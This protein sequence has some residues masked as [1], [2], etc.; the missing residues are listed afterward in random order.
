MCCKGCLLS[1]DS[2]A[3]EQATPVYT[4]GLD[5]D[6]CKRFYCSHGAYDVEEF[7][8][9]CGKCRAQH[10][11]GYAKSTDG[12]VTAF[13]MDMTDVLRLNRLTYICVKVVDHSIFG[14]FEAEVAM[15]TA[16]SM[17]ASAYDRH[18]EDASKPFC[19][20]KLLRHAVLVRLCV[21]WHE[22]V[23]A[24]DAR[25]MD[26]S[27]VFKNE[28]S[29]HAGDTPLCVRKRG[30]LRGNPNVNKMLARKQ[31][32][33]KNMCTGLIG[34]L[35]REGDAEHVFRRPWCHPASTNSLGDQASLPRPPLLR[36]WH[37]TR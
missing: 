32:L 3:A 29:T 12:R 14:Y 7:P 13:P 16:V 20:P 23:M 5:S 37:R 25:Q 28:V 8:R 33:H 2:L 30:V 24:K 1:A 21:W 9:R 6:H 18:L 36:S 27:S 22:R 11:A 31:T 4:P 17:M 19:S 26:L 10:F 34:C 35:V 15:H